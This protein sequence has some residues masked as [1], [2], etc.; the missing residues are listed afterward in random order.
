MTVFVTTPTPEPTA[1]LTAFQA[2]ATATLKLTTPQPCAETTVTPGTPEV[3][4]WPTPIPMP[5]ALPAYQVCV[6]PVPGARCVK[7][8]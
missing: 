2:Q 8:S 4:F 3:C 6:T 7:E 1:T 5:T